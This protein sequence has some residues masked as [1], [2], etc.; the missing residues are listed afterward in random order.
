MKWKLVEI[1]LDFLNKCLREEYAK[2]I[3][4]KIQNQLEEI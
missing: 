1:D 3:L 4:D 2:K